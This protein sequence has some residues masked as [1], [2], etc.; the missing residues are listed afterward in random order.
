MM[1]LEKHT[2]RLIERL[3]KVRGRL[4]EGAPL[5][6][7][8][9]FR[10]GGAAEVMFRP[11]DRD[12]LA[13]FLGGKPADVPLTVIGVGSNLLVR[14]GGVPGVVVRLGR[15]FAGIAVEGERLSAG[16]AALDVN[17]AVA[18]ADAA[19]AG[20]EFLAGIPGTIGG[21]LRMNAG[22][23][24][25]EIKD[26]IVAAEA[27]DPA[28]GS[29]ALTP[30]ELGLSYRRSALPEDW[31][32]VSATLQAERGESAAIARRMKEIENARAES[33]PI[34]GR[35]GGSTFANPS[36]PQ[37]AGRKAWQLIDAAGCRG[38]ARGGAV[39][40]EQHCNFLINTGD[41]TAGDLEALGE[42][43]RRRVFET[44]GVELCW[45]IRIIGVPSESGP[46]AL[47]RS[48]T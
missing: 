35:T 33:Q 47:Q 22:A 44:S 3:P 32:F 43:M 21:A 5:A 30:A 17:V 38:L 7:L 11:A 28:G 37:A 40:S 31:I 29:H 12:D 8:T 20:L 27:L 45:E 48:A 9:R 18:A 16:A 25:R 19:L 42:E 6:R 23:Y 39:V 4:S 36:G 10:V 1:A 2:P 34:R 26:V 41:A 46:R 14:D 13:R 24:G 15:T